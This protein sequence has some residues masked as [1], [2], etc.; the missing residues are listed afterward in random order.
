MIEEYKKL[1]R[2]ASSHW[3]DDN[4]VDPNYFAYNDL[5]H[6]CNVANER[7]MDNNDYKITGLRL[8]NNNSCVEFS[9]KIGDEIMDCPSYFLSRR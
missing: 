2:K 1:L 7:C 8:T 3:S 4:Q 6:I 5:S 9:V